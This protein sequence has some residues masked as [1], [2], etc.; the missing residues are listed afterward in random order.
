MARYRKI[1]PR[2]W[3]DEKFTSLSVYA[4]MMFLFVLTHPNMTFIGAFRASKAGL[5]QELASTQGSSE[6]IT[7]G[8]AEAY[9]KGFDEL[10]EK[11]LIWH[12]PKA[13]FVFARNFV[14]YN[15]PE[16]L[17][18]CK[19]FATA[20]EYLPECRLLRVAMASAAKI[21]KENQKPAFFDAL[22]EG[23]RKAYAEGLAEGLA[24][25]MPYPKNKELRAKKDISPVGPLADQPSESPPQTEEAQQQT[26][27]LFGEEEAPTPAPKKKPKR[28]NKP[29]VYFPETLPD[30]WRERAK[31]IR[32]DVDPQV[33]FMK[34]R[35]RYAGTSTKKTI[36]QWAEIFF[37]WLGREYARTNNSYHGKA[38][39]ENAFRGPS[40]EPGPST[41]WRAGINPDFTINKKACG[42]V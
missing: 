2:I 12:D 17:N 16:S 28:E 22:P 25:D 29:K 19:S 32:N 20:L 36:D 5:S 23:F 15:L 35:A 27:T 3:N 18:V 39:N 1:D 9:E 31:V 24:E 8:L 6:G 33:V 26:E 38:H 37:D 40:W 10:I 7:E 30:D 41:D 4:R 14:K 11:A 42:L 34:L 13:N 21:I